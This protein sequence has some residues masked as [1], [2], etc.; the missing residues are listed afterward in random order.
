MGK[1][2]WDTVTD[3]AVWLDDD[4]T[5]LPAGLAGDRYVC[6]A[7]WETV[8]LKGTKVD[9]KVAP[10]FSHKSGSDC[11]DPEREAQIDEDTEVV[12]RLRD[13][14]R[15][16][17]GVTATT[18]ILGEDGKD[19]LGLPPIIIACCG[20]TTV[21]IE[22]PGVTLP[23]P[24]ILR[25][26]IRAVRERHGGV[27][28]V[29]F[30]KKDPNQFGKLGTLKVRHGGQDDV[31]HT[32]APNEQQEV[33][34]A[35][36]GNVYWLDGKLVLIPY[37]VRWF[38]HPVKKDQDWNAWPRWR[39]DPRNDWRI[40]KPRPSADAD[41]WGL[42]P[43]ELSSMTKT[44]AVFRPSKAH[45]V[46]DELYA[47]QEQRHRWRNRRA[48]E[49]YAERH[50]P[51]PG[52]PVRADE[53][54]EQSIPLVPVQE[55][56]RRPTPPALPPNSP[57]PSASEPGPSHA[58]ATDAGSVASPSPESAP[59]PIPPQPQHPPRAVPAQRKLRRRWPAIFLPGR[60]RR[61]YR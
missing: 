23:G 40:S 22:R 50:Q 39:S 54:P 15:A 14:I 59:A 36:G 46:M 25:R 47:A 17:P 2:A 6:R 57:T 21:A 49:L 30:L 3:H 60:S 29:W 7:C 35:S 11:A 5:G 9:A 20:G 10:Y 53:L 19:P 4:V 42:V 13:T 16:L 26:R 52:P 12:I 27:E 38:Q 58:Q 61:R 18:E 34:L 45:R 55:T 44:Q 31:H 24:D 33:I 32:L 56:E 48:H 41:C 43:I 37:G 51:V 8:I 28:H 1:S